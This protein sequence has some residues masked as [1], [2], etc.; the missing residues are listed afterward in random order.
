MI[1]RRR[2]LSLTDSLNSYSFPCYPKHFES[3]E[4]FFQSFKKYFQTLEIYFE[5]FK[6]LWTR[7]EK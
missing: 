1:S 2:R 7:G 6:I 4:I 5:T 3:L